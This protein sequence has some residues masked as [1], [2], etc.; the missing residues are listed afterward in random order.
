M[1]GLDIHLPGVTAKTTFTKS[2][3]QILSR[4]IDFN[5]MKLQPDDEVIEKPLPWPSL[6]SGPLFDHL[7]LN[8]TLTLTLTQPDPSRSVAGDHVTKTVFHS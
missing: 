3:A 4:D 2:L 7:T 1:A 5:N 6:N 8:L